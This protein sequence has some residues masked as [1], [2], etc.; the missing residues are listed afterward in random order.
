MDWSWKERF[1]R[2][3]E[4]EQYL[5]QMTDYLDL[6][7]DIQ[8]NSRIASAHRDEKNNTW[9][10]TT[11]QGETFVSKFLISATGPL[12]TPLKPP[13]PGLDSFKGEW[14]QTGLWPK[15]KVD[16]SGKRV[17]LIGTG[18]TGVQIVPVLAHT[19]QSLTVFQRTPNYVMPARNHPLMEEQMNEIKQNYEKVFKRARG[20]IYGFD[21]TDSTL[22]FDQMDS[23]A[24]VQRVLEAG[25]EKGG[26]RY[27]FETF[28]DILLN[29]KSNEAASE[30]VRNKIRAIV[31]DQETA[32][33]LCPDYPIV[34]KR[35]PVG[36]HYYEAFN[37]DNVKL[38]DIK[39]NPIQEITPT[40]L[41]TGTTEYEF[42]MIIFA[43]GEF[44]FNMLLSSP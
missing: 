35:P 14:Y 9:K 2:Q 40:G 20:Q 18:A 43:I 16:F 25:W 23:D 1:P 39:N 6:R 4:V 37:R 36:H 31:N 21:M 33:L 5:N 7:K 41:K 28:G 19:V 10:V 15:H 24:K 42:D 29:P 30:F 3:D 38:V 32:E 22:M 27:V 26:F 34:S 11:A 8:F 17:A 13:F 12:A 44:P